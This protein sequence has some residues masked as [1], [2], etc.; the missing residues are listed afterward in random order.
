[1]KKSVTLMYLM[2]MAF[3][4]Q[5]QQGGISQDMLSQ[6]KSSYKHTV[7]DKAIYNAMAGTSIAVLAKNH[8]NLANFDT[9]FSDKVVSHGITDQQQSGRCWLFTGLNVL[10]AQMMAKYGIDDMEFSQNYCFFYDQLE[11]ANLFLQGIIDTREKPMD[12]KMVEWLFRNPI[13]DGGQFTEISDI[14]EKYGVVPAAV[15]PETY[16]S[17]NT[18]QISRLVGLKLKEFG[19]KLRDDAAKGAKENALAKTKTDMLC[20][21]YHM[22]ALAFGEPVEHF[23]WTVKGVTKEYTPQSFYKEFLGNDLKNGYVMLM[24]DPSREFYKCYEIDFDRHVYD[25]KNWTYVNL[26]IEEIKEMAIKSIKDSTMM[27]FSCDVAKFMDSKRGTLDLNNFDYD[28][29]LGTTFGMDKKQRIQ[30]F[31]S[32]SSH[33]MTLMAVDLDKDGKPKKWM[34]E[35]S[36]GAEAGYKGHLIMTDEWFN[37]YMFRLVVEK[38]YVSDK[39]LDILK[40]KPIRLPAWDPMFASEE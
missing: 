36:W 11:K 20:T 17:E 15:M 14:I 2:A 26:P 37:E 4:A 6:I 33:A 12:D 10:R 16:S 19:L 28:S 23:T 13:N 5:A 31:A 40:Q 38:K 3:S 27:Y 35:N 8:E 24:N 1:M 32:G 22:L 39:V 9:H 25:G 21:V 34:V 18:S 29:L 7:A 30:T